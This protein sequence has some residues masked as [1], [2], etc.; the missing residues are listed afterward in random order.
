MW[1]MGLRVE[2]IVNAVKK[3]KKKKTERERERTNTVPLDLTQRNLLVILIRAVFIRLAE[4]K[5]FCTALCLL[6]TS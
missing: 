6:F 1:V 5:V 2:G 4:T 3:K